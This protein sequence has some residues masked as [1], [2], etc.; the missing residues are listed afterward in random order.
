MRL[1]HQE[2]FQEAMAAEMGQLA[3]QVQSLVTFVQQLPMPTTAQVI[4]PLGAGIKLAPPERY[5]GDPG[6]CKPFLTD[7]LIHFDHS[8][9]IFSMDHSKI[10]FMISHLTGRAKVWATAKWS[11]NS[12]QSP[13][14][15]QNALKR[16]FNPLSSDRELSGLRQDSGSVWDYAIHFRTLA[17]ESRWNYSKMSSLRDS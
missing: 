14:Q 9:Q 11:R 16:T 3:A 15:F 5:S 13:P 10:T 4:Y 7:C 6:K 12:L 2:E 1:T 17:L 8:P